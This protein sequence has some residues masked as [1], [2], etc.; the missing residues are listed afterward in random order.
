MSKGERVDV[1]RAEIAARKAAVKALDH[2]RESA[3][4]ELQ[5]VEAELAA[6]EDAHSAVSSNTRSSGTPA[7]TTA[8]EKVAL[9][10]SLF[11]RDVYPKLWINAKSGRT[12]CAPDCAN[13]W[14]RGLC[15]KPRVR[16]GDCLNQAFIGVSDRV[17]ADHLQGRHVVGVYPLLA[18][19]HCWFVAVDF[20]K[21]GGRR[22]RVQFA[23]RACRRAY[24]SPS[25]GLGPGMAR[26]LGSSSKLR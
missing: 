7:P 20:D 4:D 14:V 13:E 15:E 19:D 17:I 10:R 11:R 6:L 24:R 3:Q 22:I 18:D 2:Q 16:C 12:G 26:T 25:N 9:F 8:T 21:G 1:L 5:R 23:T